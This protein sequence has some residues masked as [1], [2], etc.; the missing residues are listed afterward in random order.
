LAWAVAVALP[1]SRARAQ[2]PTI[3]PAT[4]A[5]GSSASTLGP[6]P[7][8]GASSPF[9]AQ[10]RG[11]QFLG[12]RPGTSTSRAPTSISTPGGGQPAPSAGITAPP[13]LPI[14]ELP[15]F[16]TLALPTGPEDEGPPDGL[17]LDMAIER[18]I[19]QN[20]DLRARFYEIPMAE[21]DVLTASLRANPILYADGQLVPY[22]NYSKARPGGQT[23]YDL[24]VSYPLD[25][26]H[27]RRARTTAAGWT[28][29]TLEAQYQDAVRVQIGQLYNAFVNVLAERGTVRYAE[30]SVR[31]MD[32]FLKVTKEMLAISELRTR[33][34]LNNIKLERDAADIGLNEAREKVREAK[35][36][37]GVLLNMTPAEAQLIEVRGSI[38]DLAPTPPSLEQ[39]VPIALASR[40]DLIAYRLGIR[41][42]E[43]EVDLAKANRF[44]DAYLLYQP[45]TF[46]SNAPLHLKSPT[47]WALGITV[48]LPVYNRNQ[49]NIQRAHLNVGQTQVQLAA[50]ERLVV[51]EV[52]QAERDYS[53]SRATLARVERDL[54][55][56]AT[57]GMEDT[58]VLYQEGERNVVDF[59]YARKRYNDAVKQYRDTA[60]RHRR[61]M[62]GLNT[63][64]GRRLLP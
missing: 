45:Y 24:N 6:T 8:A 56:A 1:A 31:G 15:L 37:L 17:T 57:Q 11:P 44:A 64:V 25:L 33:A 51:S 58:R 47:S 36:A 2:A 20:L 13:P 49:G 59:L 32:E 12:G 55:P 29:E 42:A 18:L 4:P 53:V 63:A 61:S 30:A 35:R 54:L 41:R 39:L 50:L 14:S 16:G 34:E 46:Q 48:P 19:H 62:L 5:P 7:G 40:P 23:Q 43:S 28:R 38:R 26:S 3:Q 27:K 22:G 21:A 10:G 60:I 52:E 9:A